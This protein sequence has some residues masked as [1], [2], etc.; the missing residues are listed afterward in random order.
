MLDQR[1]THGPVSAN[2]TKCRTLRQWP[3]S[4]WGKH[5][6]SPAQGGNTREGRSDPLL[7]AWPLLGLVVHVQQSGG[8]TTSNFEHTRGLRETSTVC[9]RVSRKRLHDTHLAPGSI[10][11]AAGRQWLKRT[12]HVARQP[13]RLLCPR[14]MRSTSFRGCSTGAARRAGAKS[15][16]RE[17]GGRRQ[18]APSEHFLPS[19]GK[20]PPRAGGSCHPVRSG[21][22]G[23]PAGPRNQPTSGALRPPGR[24]ALGSRGLC[25][26]RR[27]RAPHIG[28]CI[29][30]LGDNDFLRG[31]RLSQAPFEH[32][33]IHGQL[34]GASWLALPG[35]RESFGKRNEP[36]PWQR[37]NRRWV[38]A[39]R[40]RHERSGMLNDTEYK[41]ADTVEHTH[42]HTPNRCCR[43]QADDI[44]R[45]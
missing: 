7:C 23:P 38:C 18:S 19:C 26:S 32:H 36:M 29:G 40:Y 15:R 43:T 33:T 16:P 27:G 34:R 20:L 4:A 44:T 21:V 3:R 2:S 6:S 12:E 45:L 14:L 31:A 9:V 35:S 25:I 22:A 24:R 8:T 10:R 41:R 13:R 1:S 28:N 39:Q 5:K 17:G 11:L 42:T 37:K 30:A